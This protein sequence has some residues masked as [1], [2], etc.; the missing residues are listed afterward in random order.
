MS[1]LRSFLRCKM[2]EKFGHVPLQKTKFHT[3]DELLLGCWTTPVTHVSEPHTAKPRS[4]GSLDL[5]T[6]SPSIG[7]IRFSEWLKCC[8]TDPVRCVL[9]PR[10]SPFLYAMTPLRP[11]TPCCIGTIPRLG[12]SAVDAIETTY[13]SKKK[14][15][16]GLVKVGFPSLPVS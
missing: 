13:P 9:L 8:I 3:I 11:D 4:V 5:P 14:R 10:I 16:K 15:E 6:Y 7:L 1:D 2:I 12:T